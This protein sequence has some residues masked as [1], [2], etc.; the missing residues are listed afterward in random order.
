MGAKFYYKLILILSVIFIS[1]SSSYAYRYVYGLSC[2]NRNYC[3]DSYI[4]NIYEYWDDGTPKDEWGE[5]KVR[6]GDF[7][8][9]ILDDPTPFKSEDIVSFFLSDFKLDGLGSTCHQ[10]SMSL[11]WDYQ[12]PFRCLNE[13]T[14]KSEHMRNYRFP[15]EITPTYIDPDGCQHW[16]ITKKKHVVCEYPYV[17]T[18]KCCENA[19]YYNRYCRVGESRSYCSRYDWKKY[20][21]KIIP[22]EI[23]DYGGLWT[24]NE[25]ETL[26]YIFQ[27]N[28]EMVEKY[29]NI[30]L[31]TFYHETEY[32]KYPEDTCHRSWWIIY[33]KDETFDNWF[34]DNFGSGICKV[35]GKIFDKSKYKGEEIKVYGK[36]SLK[37][38]HPVCTINKSR[39]S[40][41]DLEE[42]AKIKYIEVKWFFNQET[43]CGDGYCD[44]PETHIN[45]PEDCFHID[46]LE[47]R[48]IS[49]KG[50]FTT[51]E[52]LNFGISLVNQ[53]EP[54][55]LTI[56][57]TI[58]YLPE[59]ECEKIY[60]FVKSCE[61][62]ENCT[63]NTHSITHRPKPNIGRDPIGKTIYTTPVLP[64]GNCKAV[65]TVCRSK[66]GIKPGE[67][68]Y[69]STVNIYKEKEKINC[70]NIGKKVDSC[71]GLENCY[72]G[73]PFF[74]KKPPRPRLGPGYVIALGA[75]DTC[76]QIVESCEYKDVW[77]VKD[78]GKIEEENGSLF[79]FTF[80]PEVEG[81]Y[82]VSFYALD[83]IDLDTAFYSTIVNISKKELIIPTPIIREQEESSKIGFIPQSGNGKNSASADS[84]LESFTIVAALFGTITL[85]GF[86]VYSRENG[87]VSLA[88]R[89]EKSIFN[90]TQSIENLK[91]QIVA[92]QPKIASESFLENYEDGHETFI[93]SWKERNRREAI[94]RM[95]ERERN[96]ELK[97]K[98]IKLVEEFLDSIRGLSPE[99]QLFEIELFIN[100]HKDELHPD[101]RALLNNLWVDMKELEKFNS[102]EKWNANKEATKWKVFKQLYGLQDFTADELWKS[103][104]VIDK[105]D[106]YD[107]DF[108]YLSELKTRYGTNDIKTIFALLLGHDVF[109]DETEQFKFDSDLTPP[110]S[111]KDTEE[112]INVIEEVNNLI[113]TL[114]S[115]GKSIDFENISDIEI[116]IFSS[117]IEYINSTLFNISE[118]LKKIYGTE[119]VKQAVNDY[120]VN[121]NKLVPNSLDVIPTT[122]KEDIPFELKSAIYY[123]Y[124]TLN[125]LKEVSHLFKYEISDAIGRM[126]DYFD[127]VSTATLFFPVVDDI[128][129]TI[130]CIIG[131]YDSKRMGEDF[132][133]YVYA[134]A[135]ALNA[136]IDA[137]IAKELLLKPKIVKKLSKI[138]GKNEDEVAKIIENLDL[139][140]VS[141]A[142]YSFE[143]ISNMAKVAG[144]Y[145]DLG[146]DVT[147]AKALIKS[148]K[149]MFDDL[150]YFIDI[151]KKAGKEYADDVFDKLLSFVKKNG[152][153]AIKLL[154]KIPTDNLAPEF[155]EMLQKGGDDFLKL[156][157]KSD[158]IPQLIDDFG[159][160][161]KRLDDY[162]KN[163]FKHVLS[164]LDDSFSAE[165]IKV[166]P[167]FIEDLSDALKKYN[168]PEN[169]FTSIKPL[170]EDGPKIILKGDTVILHIDPIESWPVRHE[171]SHYVAFKPFENS[172]DV[173]NRE[174]ASILKKMGLDVDLDTIDEVLMP[175]DEM[176]AWKLQIKN[177]GKE[178]TTMDFKNLVD[179]ELNTFT[180]NIR[181]DELKMVLSTLSL[182]KA[183]AELLG[184]NDY[185]TKIDNVIDEILTKK[186]G[187]LFVD[188]VRKGM[189]NLI[190][191]LKDIDVEDMSASMQARI[192]KKLYKGV[193]KLW[194][195][196]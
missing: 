4:D 61:G 48:N 102:G 71:E 177:F 28:K 181:K 113:G 40:I 189:D 72:C 35:E 68:F 36:I 23:E 97:A 52:P 93:E 185:V 114:L 111:F 81:Q 63:C 196:L 42:D 95:E 60:H 121:K 159:V 30:T 173:R 144:K 120:V 56:Q 127:M 176:I 14:L 75:S 5:H 18:A 22:E 146:L 89:V 193:D 134:V 83:M 169:I 46:D 162:D 110:S 45:C 180:G 54:A 153:D 16:N 125:L 13:F 155:F 122:F 94:E 119:L 118:A 59:L 98:S 179:M 158:N 101:A 41:P 104:L 139:S 1:I 123:Y 64:R 44:Y 27:N 51:Y 154:K 25:K 73:R 192:F 126:R 74:Y 12:K 20:K 194:R 50:N 99:R 87:V 37:G 32:W 117:A 140:G 80:I 58:E 164:V 183:T 191:I 178:L 187:D 175:F 96:E 103:G 91:N 67:L 3:D 24:D 8:K 138:L 88:K 135:L 15:Y 29:G 182:R 156:L 157:G 163:V 76:I 65:E 148:G 10:N 107:I 49:I 129:D 105:G 77:K 106:Y 69:A 161:W 39:S 112:I 78:H 136:I 70:H 149:L 57:M 34:V 26:S 92:Q 43:L 170:D 132:D 109:F 79:I 165:E 116:A 9:F 152:D 160:V 85:G 6:W 53:T 90:A 47:F 133:F 131:M 19:G 86:Y 66:N 7:N 100:N 195:T 166:M 171:I 184:L 115:L 38:N 174:V 147:K 82:N 11:Y 142:K 84:K 167:R 145:I 2:S 108:D 124:D 137:N 33:S 21:C 62:Y 130:D 150:G 143:E 151:L 141:L 190:K 168:L 128:V 186:V 188:K 31:K 172:I 55:N 17:F